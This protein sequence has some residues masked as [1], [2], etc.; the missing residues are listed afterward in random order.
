MAL[1]SRASMATP[2]PL[3]EEVAAVAEKRPLL[4]SELELEARLER[5]RRQG[6]EGLKA[7]PAQAELRSALDR[8]VDQLLV[9]QEAERLQLFEPPPAE[10][11]TALA[12]LRALAVGVDLDRLL[13]EQGLDAAMLRDAVRREVRVRRY[14]DGR[15]RLAARP[16]DSELRRYWREHPELWQGR[17]LAQAAPELRQRLTTLRFVELA[18]AFVAD[19]RRR[20]D[21]EVLHDFDRPGAGLPTRGVATVAAESQ[22]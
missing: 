3:L 1:W 20:A 10:I 4:L 14:L 7:I 16:R 21:V 17:T 8:L 9:Y 11:A 15:F 2:G 19:L 22:P 12:E 18:A 6:V 5:L 13:V